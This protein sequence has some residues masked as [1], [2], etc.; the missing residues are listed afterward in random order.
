MRADLVVRSTQVVAPSGIAPAALHIVDGRLARLTNYNDCPAGVPLDDAGDLVV[1][2]GLVDAHVHFNEPGR[3]EWEG[4]ETGTSAAAAGGVTTAVDMPLNSVPATTSR[5]S[6]DRKRDA[7]EGKL[8]ID[9]AFWGGVVPGNAADL[10]S[11][12]TAVAG[13]KAFMVPSGVDEFPAVS[14]SDLREALPILADLGLPLLVH[15]EAPMVIEECSAALAAGH[16]RSHSTWLASRPAVA[17]VA[18]INLLIALCRE[19]RARIHIVHLS[20]SEAVPMIQAAR[21]EW[22][23][24]TVETCPHYL[25]FA[26]EKIRAGATEFKCAPPIR[27]RSNQA[28]LWQAVADGVVDLIASDHSPCPPA[29]KELSSGDFTRAWGG[30]GSIE[31]SLAAVWTG[32][33][34]R[35]ISIGHVASLMCARPAELAGLGARKG[36]IAKGFDADLVIW[37]PDAEFTVLQE[38]LVQRHKI[39]PY[40]GLRLRG[41]V[42]RTYVRGNLA[43]RRDDPGS[44]QPKH[45][46]LIVRSSP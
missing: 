45:G 30:I 42:A 39:T 20:A 41:Q 1:M 33:A 24:L 7:A 26:A 31:L 4:F 32:A 38:E 23:P 34:N 14:E 28:R 8:H 25:T 27:E 18:A 16:A 12:A 15:A 9:V 17:E 40:N 29:M 44:L 13:F 10:P 2:P 21:A 36:R 6:L 19:Y 3:T 37:D 35:G 11:L 43:Y 5:H 22:L 46:K